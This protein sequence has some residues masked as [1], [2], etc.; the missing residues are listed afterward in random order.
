MDLKRK[1]KS[2]RDKLDIRNER[3]REIE[4]GFKIMMFYSFSPQ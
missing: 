3:E 4:R 1:L 2:K